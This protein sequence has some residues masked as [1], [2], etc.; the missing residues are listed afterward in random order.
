MSKN[1]TSFDKKSVSPYLFN[2]ALYNKSN[3]LEFINLIKIKK[4]GVEKEILL[5]SLD[6]LE[7]EFSNYRL[8][9]KIVF[10]KNFKSITG[11]NSKQ[12]LFSKSSSPLFHFSYNAVV[13]SSFSKT[14]L[15]CFFRVLYCITRINTINSLFKKNVKKI[16]NNVLFIFNL[17]P[18]KTGYFCYFSGVYGFMSKGFCKKKTKTK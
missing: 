1:L 4:R 6:N 10:K 17:T 18:Q 12:F 8:N 16:Y 14:L 13:F 5:A 2:S 11:I 9:S 15:L 3:F 7:D